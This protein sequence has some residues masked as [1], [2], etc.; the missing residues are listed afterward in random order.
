MAARREPLQRHDVR[1]PPAGSRMAGA[2]SPPGPL[3]AA[4]SHLRLPPGRATPSRHPARRAGLGRNVVSAR[5]AA[6]PTIAPHIRG[7]LGDPYLTVK[8]GAR[9][10][11]VTPRHARLWCRQTRERADDRKVKPSVF[12]SFSA[13]YRSAPGGLFWIETPRTPPC[14]VERG[15]G[16]A[17]PFR[18][19][20]PAGR[21][22]AWEF[23]APQPVGVS[24]HRT[25]RG[26]LD[27]S[28]RA[29][30]CSWGHEEVAGGRVNKRIKANGG[31]LEPE[32]AETNQGSAT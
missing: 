27:Q 32:V 3:A 28:P 14:G 21:G 9:V 26:P 10:V 19:D 18:A 30:P 20:C 7:Q 12:F 29:S 4:P 15:R 22:R 8:Y 1:P 11:A 31:H 17:A 25:R 23:G 24:L 2:Q 5:D 16:D 13:L 6:E